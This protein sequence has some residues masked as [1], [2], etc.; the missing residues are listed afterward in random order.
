MELYPK[1]PVF[2]QKHRWSLVVHFRRNDFKSGDKIWAAVESIKL[3]H[4]GLNRHQFPPG[5]VRVLLGSVCL[6]SGFLSWVTAGAAEWPCQES[7]LM[8]CP[9]RQLALPGGSVWTGFRALREAGLL[10]GA[11]PE[12]MVL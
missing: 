4:E 9:C 5:P 12:Q 2:L 7:P 3:A 8:L 10:P 1:A 11:S 6:F